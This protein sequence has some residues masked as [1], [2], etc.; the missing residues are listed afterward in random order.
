MRAIDAGAVAKAG[1][2]GTIRERLHQ[3]RVRAVEDAL[4]RAGGPGPSPAATAGSSTSA[5]STSDGR[6]G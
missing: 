1:P 6:T 5:G 3:A 4:L 2:P